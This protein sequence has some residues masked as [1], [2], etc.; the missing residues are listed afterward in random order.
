MF[1]HRDGKTY[2]LNL[3]DTPVGQI[4]LAPFSPNRLLLQGRECDIHRQAVFRYNCFP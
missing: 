4:P 2:L 3:I 1:Y